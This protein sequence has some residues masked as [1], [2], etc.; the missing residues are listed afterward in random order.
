MAVTD[1][2]NYNQLKYSIRMNLCEEEISRLKEIENLPPKKWFWP[3]TPRTGDH[4]EIIFQR[5]GA[6]DADYLKKPSRTFKIIRAIKKSGTINNCSI[7]DIGSG[8][9]VVLSVLKEQ[10]PGV[11]PIALEP[12]VDSFDTH[13]RAKNLG[14]IF[15]KGFIQDIVS[16]ESVSKFDY[17]L[18]LNSYRSWSHAGLGDTDRETP[19]E[20]DR[21]L[22]K[23]ALN[24][25]CTINLFQLFKFV[26]LGR[27]IRILGRGE[28]R[29]IMILWKTGCEETK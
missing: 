15:I 17:V 10:F 22:K 29:S 28:D 14:V 20:L 7:L 11:M 13:A 1:Y 19:K 18:I 27:K 25:I 24:V 6:Y 3:N 9:A 16:Y 26:V 4:Q 23:Q 12:L 21:W 8:D 2:Y 5:C